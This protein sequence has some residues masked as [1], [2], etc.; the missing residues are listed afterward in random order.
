MSSF[1]HEEGSR[2]PSKSQEFWLATSLVWSQS[3]AAKIA[4]TR[5]GKLNTNTVS[6]T[7]EI[8]IRLCSI[9]IRAHL[10]YKVQGN[11]KQ[12]PIKNSYRNGAFESEGIVAISPQTPQGLIHGQ[13]ETLY[14]WLSRTEPQQWVKVTWKAETGSREVQLSQS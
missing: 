5:P 11:K 8:I 4:N 6:R 13:G 3:T 9:L 7:S 12:Y 1:M 14:T 2:P 10:E